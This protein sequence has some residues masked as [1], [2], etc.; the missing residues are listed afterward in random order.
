[1]G[2]L[3][4]P[5][6][7]ES[8]PRHA[9][10]R[11]ARAYIADFNSQPDLAR[12]VGCDPGDIRDVTAKLLCKYFADGRRTPRSP[13]LRLQFTHDCLY[14]SCSDPA[15][16]LCRQSQYRRCNRTF[17]RKY[18]S[19]DVLKATCN[20]NI[21]VQVIDE[22]TERP[23]HDVSLLAG[24]ELQFFVLDGKVAELQGSLESGTDL[25]S[26]MLLF[27]HQNL[28]LLMAR[29]LG[30]GSDGFVR[31]PLSSASLAL[32]DLAVTGSSEALL[33]G[34]KPPLILAARAVDAAGKIAEH[35][36]PVFSEGFV[37]ATP[38]VRTAAKNDIPHCEDNVC[39][40]NA[41]GNATQ[42]KLKD[43]A[44]AAA[45][46]GIGSF[47][48]P[49][50]SVNKV[51]ELQA[52]MVWAEESLERC[53]ATKKIL[54]LTKG[55]EEAREHV[56]KAVESD[57]R[58]RLWSSLPSGSLVG[59]LFPTSGA[60]PLLDSPLALVEEGHE[61]E[62]AGPVVRAVM[63][64]KGEGEVSL[65]AVRE[66]LAEAQASWSRRGHPGWSMLP[67][68]SESFSASCSRHISIVLPLSLLEGAVPGI[69][70]P[71]PGLGMGDALGPG[72][73]PGGAAAGL[74]MSQRLWQLD[75]LGTLRS[76]VLGA[77]PHD[78]GAVTF[79]GMAPP[80]YFPDPFGAA[81]AAAAAGSPLAARPG[82]SGAAGD[83]FYAS[84]SGSAALDLEAKPFDPGQAAM[85]ATYTGR[86]SGGPAPPTPEGGW[87]GGGGPPGP[88]TGPAHT[89]SG[90][91]STLHEEGGLSP[92]NK[93]ARMGP[94]RPEPRLAS[95][96]SNPLLL[97][98]LLSLGQAGQD[99]LRNLYLPS[100][101]RLLDGMPSGPNFQ[102]IEQPPLGLESLAPPS[103]PID[104]AAMLRDAY[105]PYDPDPAPLPGPAGPGPP[106]SP[107]PSA[108]KPSSQA[109]EQLLKA[110]G[111]FDYAS[112]LLDRDGG[113]H[114]PHH[115]QQHPHHGREEGRL[116]MPPL[117]LL[118]DQGLDPEGGARDHPAT[119]P[120]LGEAQASAEQ[121][122]LR[123]LI[124]ITRRSEHDV[125][126]WAP[127]SQGEAV[128]WGRLL[129]METHPEWS[130][131]VQEVH[132]TMGPVLRPD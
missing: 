60:T 89:A 127:E 35:I 53:D 49:F 3:V 84:G 129:S 105:R 4:P 67:M 69:G 82:R 55:W 90:S 6:E 41:V 78:P 120:G 97:S 52:L 124:D 121:E 99:Q 25:E 132:T 65:G 62:E 130:R 75:S 24:L 119:G 21:K 123:N 109:L 125:G 103:P 59:L 71:M 44:R 100:L 106:P 85:A 64:G 74:S 43:L 118:G 47:A 117:A 15:C 92:V 38:R 108:H 72:P 91:L 86:G 50:H 20:A 9:L 32:P 98:K 81:A 76:E 112:H 73:D 102:M 17:A 57:T 87:D 10:E 110:A 88:G 104:Y 128:G 34:Q 63:L 56:F 58:L 16:E 37:V 45:D 114:H 11:F 7:L 30:A 95:I 66:L 111:R 113:G 80:A 83:P 1:M 51:R 46:A 33:K 122:L 116:G 31:L 19:G 26:Y 101:S 12:C 18:L 36:L 23:V 8:C 14:H 93:R 2:W 126:R 48:F 13:R 61:R 94:I 22:E 68:D 40:I 70:L 29:Q 79:P 77:P 115:A 96:P 28:P 42:T 5:P 107:P 131:P 54:K 39:K 27:N